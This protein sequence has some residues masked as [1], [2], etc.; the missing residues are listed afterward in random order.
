MSEP[1]DDESTTRAPQ[2]A[3][4][5]R[6]HRD[7]RPSRSRSW[8]PLFVAA[9][10]GALVVGGAWWLT[11]QREPTAPAPLAPAPKRVSV[12][13]AV[14][15]ASMLVATLDV[16][17]LR[18]SPLVGPYLG[19]ERSVDGLGT[20]RE[21][22]GFDP[23]ERVDELAFVVPTDGVDE[24][25][26][27]AM[28]PVP[29][30][31]LLGCA[32][33]LIAARGGRPVRS[34]LGG[35]RTVRDA[36]TASTSAGEIALRAMPTAERSGGERTMI[37]VGS[38]SSLRGMIDAA[39]GA[40]PRFESN[41]DHAALRSELAS[42]P[43][44]RASLVLSSEQRRSID[45]S[46]G[47]AEPELAEAMRSLRGAALGVRLDGPRAEVAVVA[48][49]QSEAHARSFASV[50]DPARTRLA[51]APAVE[52]LGARSLLDRARI[53]PTEARVRL[54]LASDASEL[55]TIAQ[56]ALAARA[57]FERTNA[58]AVDPSASP[59]PSG[60]TTP[61]ARPAASARPQP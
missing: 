14:P 60:S 26:L 17:A 57:M 12:L 2:R 50:V 15:E 19:G 24:L 25:G 20:L 32:E 10:A 29:E 22:C 40:T 51:K 38:G 9:A 3:G 44:M 59:S 31:A 11:E 47:T 8:L 43:A 42:Y 33:R 28:G 37:L 5:P 58:A 16:R 23:I 7:D 35:F 39:E 54:E 61:V 56:R 41:R 46:L 30:E 13:D 18:A 21:A 36:S 49:L 34:S 45:A 4:E 48:D 53:V 27:A 1:S 55:G 52:L 6:G